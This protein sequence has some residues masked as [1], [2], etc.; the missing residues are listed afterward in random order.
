M[1][2]SAVAFPRLRL[3]KEDAEVSLSIRIA[4]E[5]CKGKL[6]TLNVT[7]QCPG[8]R[9]AIFTYITKQVLTT[10]DIQSV[11]DDWMT[12]DSTRSIL[13]L[14]RGLLVG[15][16]LAFALRQ[17]RWRVH[18]GRTADRVPPTK[19][20][21]PYRAKDTP[22][23]RSEFSYPDVVIILT[24]LSYYY[25]G[26][27]DGDLFAAFTHLMNADQAAIEYQQWVKDA[28]SL[29]PAF[30]QLAGINLKDRPQCI[31]EI[32]PALRHGKSV[33]DYFLSRLVF[34]REMREFPHKL[35]V[36][37]WDI[38]KSK[39]LATTGFSGTIDSRFLLPLDTAYLNLEDP[40]AYKCPGI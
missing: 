9:D 22:S 10:E 32:F 36:S 27:N 29:A 21:V 26:L 1:T 25:E 24:S 33:I 5:I 40:K 11:E 15:G 39:K 4:D 28:S 31:R 12:I 30:R 34:P 13:L 20:A 8:L 35:S 14:L 2:A 16:V 6:D 18:Y 37:G 38:G 3:L 7:R 23:P 19:L 17:K